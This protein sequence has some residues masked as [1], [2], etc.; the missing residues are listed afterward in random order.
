MSIYFILLLLIFS[1]A[2]LLLIHIASI[3]ILIKKKINFSPL[4]VAVKC[5]LFGNIPLIL[6]ALFFLIGRR[7]EVYEIINTIL[8]ILIIYNALGYSY[9]HTFNMSETARRIRT[10]YELN[11]AGRLRYNELPDK[12]GVKN[13]LDARLERLINMGQVSK[14]NGHFMLKSFLLYRIGMVILNWGF[15]LK[16]NIYLKQ[17]LSE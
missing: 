5:A 10:L 11:L 3:R 9:C 8:Y 13:M 7:T 4:L 15:F 6:T 12:Y 17:R 2:F 16:Y 14:H 1:Q